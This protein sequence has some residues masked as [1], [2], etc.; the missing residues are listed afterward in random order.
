M[1]DRADPVVGRADLAPPRPR[2]GAVGAVFAAVVLM[3][4]FAL[5]FLQT[6]IRE[7]IRAELW[8]LEAGH[9]A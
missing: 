1:A 3:L 6:V 4:A 7:A 5:L 2:A 9:A 8:R